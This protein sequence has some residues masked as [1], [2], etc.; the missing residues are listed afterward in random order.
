MRSFGTV[1]PL[2]GT[3]ITVP[4]L[5]GAFASSRLTKTYLTKQTKVHPC[6]FTIYIIGGVFCCCLVV[7]VVD[8]VCVWVFCVCVGF[9]FFVFVVVFVCGFFGG[10]GG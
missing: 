6:H 3:E 1:S 2:T 4:L 10:E 5:G 7:V 8:M 9:S